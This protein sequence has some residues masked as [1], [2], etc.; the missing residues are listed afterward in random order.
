MKEKLINVLLRLFGPEKLLDLGLT[1]A[2]KAL[3]F[4]DYEVTIPKEELVNDMLATVQSMTE[5]GKISTNEIA[6]KFVTKLRE[7]LLGE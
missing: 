7:I 3:K 6:D 4:L 5:D 2:Y 1:I